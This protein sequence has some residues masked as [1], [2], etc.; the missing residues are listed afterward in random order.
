MN[1]RKIYF[2]MDGVLADFDKGLLEFCHLSPISQSEKTESQDTEM[3][4]AIRQVEHFY[5]KLKPMPGA[6]EMFRVIYEK[7]GNR[8][9]ILTGIPKK[10][11]G[12]VTA[13]EDKI[14]WAHRILT[15]DIVV[16]I[17]YAEDKKNFCTGSDCVL[18]DD[19]SKNINAWI[20]SGGTGILFESFELTMKLLREKGIV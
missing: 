15:P 9:E 10:K 19:M 17:V 3:W 7:Y 4:N 8:C 14:A 20:N 16:N 18:I 13:G 5:D 2:D 6:M 1:I 12:I 11:R